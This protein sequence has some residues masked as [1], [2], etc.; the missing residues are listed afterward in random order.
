MREK[1]ETEIFWLADKLKKT[2]PEIRAMPARDL[3]G[4]REF[5]NIRAVLTDLA[6]RT[7]EHRRAGS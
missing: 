3:I 4:L 7:E 1:G 5:Y 6:V 2:P